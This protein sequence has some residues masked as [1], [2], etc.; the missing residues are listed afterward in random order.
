MVKTRVGEA[1]FGQKVK[2]VLICQGCKV[3][4]KAKGGMIHAGNW[5]IDE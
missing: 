5:Y 4:T 1:V 3:E 2:H